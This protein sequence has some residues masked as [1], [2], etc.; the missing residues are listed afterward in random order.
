M[1]SL[2]IAMCLAR[3][4]NYMQLLRPLPTLDDLLEKTKSKYIFGMKE[5]QFWPQNYNSIAM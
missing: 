2:Q 3:E 1:T 5:R 4:A